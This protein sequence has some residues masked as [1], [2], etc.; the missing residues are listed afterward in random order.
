MFLTNSRAAAFS[1]FLLAVFLKEK[2]HFKGTAL[3]WDAVGVT[4]LSQPKFRLFL[5]GLMRQ[6][7]PYQ[8]WAARGALTGH[9]RDMRWFSQESNNPTSP[10]CSEV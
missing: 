1:L 10:S 4:V 9:E 7:N 2:N 3:A 6:K 5:W 8:C